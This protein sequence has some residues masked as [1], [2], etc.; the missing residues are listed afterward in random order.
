[1]AAGS[2]KSREIQ[3]ITG[4]SA[5]NFADLVRTAQLISDPGGG[6][7]GKISQPDWEGLEIPPGVVENLKA[8]GSKYQYELPHIEP[9]IVWEQLTP[10][11]RSWVIENKNILW[12]F[13]ELF[14][15][16]DED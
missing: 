10:E 13:E 1:M 16:L 7:S 9:E 14:P 4:L 8:L 3:D 12:E 11:S 15:P 5:T 6:V 2:D